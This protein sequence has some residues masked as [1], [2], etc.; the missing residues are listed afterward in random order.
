M[1]VQVAGK[2]VTITAIATDGSNK[3]ATIKIK[4]K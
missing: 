3:K 2:K 4:L 1:T